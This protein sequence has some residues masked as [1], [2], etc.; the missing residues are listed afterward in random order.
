M[1]RPTEGDIMTKSCGSCSLCCKLVPVAEIEKPRNTWCPHCTKP[2]CAIYDDRPRGCRQWNCYWLLKDDWPA[3]LEPRRC[4]VVVDIVTEVI[5]YRDTE[6]GEPK[7]P[8]DAI[9][10]WVDPA[11]PHA[12]RNPLLRALLA[13]MC[14][15]IDVLVLVR[16]G[17]RQFLLIPPHANKGEWWERPRQPNDNMPWLE[18]QKWEQQIWQ[19]RKLL[20][21]IAP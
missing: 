8:W 2:G 10:L 17:L 1:A 4:H 20:P 21:V 19:R 5:T 11:F 18:N 6:T 12:H 15:K 14:E 13:E 16:T 7:H 9:Q 3:E